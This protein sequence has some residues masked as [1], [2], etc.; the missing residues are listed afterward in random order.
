[1]DAGNRILVAVLLLAVAFSLPLGCA[2]A[3]EASSGPVD[4]SSALLVNESRAYDGVEVAY[5][6][7]VVGVVMD[8]G[9][10][11][12]V[13]VHDGDYAIGVYA[14]AEMLDKI[15]FFGDYHQKGDIVEVTG[16]FHRACQEHGGDMDI[17]AT[18][19]EVVGRG[20][21]LEHPVSMSKVFFTL[22]LVVINIPFI[23]LLN[24]VKEASRK[25]NAT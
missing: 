14:P 22:L 5:L 6:G 12:W 15:R 10:N 2:S 17:H 18:S 23:M 3:Q 24:R 16:V 25:K 8:R 9:S 4:V 11:G 7:E 13:N 1:M 20:Y 19:V 21:V